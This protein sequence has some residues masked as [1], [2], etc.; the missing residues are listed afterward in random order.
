MGSLTPLHA[1][2][3]GKVLLAA[4]TTDERSQVFKA[5]GL[6]ARTPRTV[7]N[8]GELEKELLEVAKNGFAIVHGEFEIGLTAVAAP[9]FNHAGTVIAAISISGPAFRFVP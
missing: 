6:P 1:T 2:S 7:T 5:V 3:S 9:I 4:L 8:R